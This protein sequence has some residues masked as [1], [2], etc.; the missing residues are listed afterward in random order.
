MGSPPVGWLTVLVHVAWLSV[1]RNRSFTS[2]KLQAIAR[3]LW[4]IRT[5]SV[6]L[7]RDRLHQAACGSVTHKRHRLV[8]AAMALGRPPALPSG[9]SLALSE[10]LA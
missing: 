2:C 3:F 10:L 7:W 6:R 8:A 1:A 9:P 4:G 5:C